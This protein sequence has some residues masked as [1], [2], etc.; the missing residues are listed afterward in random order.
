MDTKEIL[1]QLAK[2]I[3]DEREL[4]ANTATRVGSLF[5]AMV[6]FMGDGEFLHKDKEDVTKFLLECLGGL[7]VEKGLKADSLEVEGEST[8]GGKVTAN[9]L[10]TGNEGLIGKSAI[11]TE[12]NVCPGLTEIVEDSESDEVGTGF[13]EEVSEYTGNST[14]GGLLNVSSGADTAP[15]GTVLVMQNG[16]YVPEIHSI[17]LNLNATASE[18]WNLLI[19]NPNK[20]FFG[21]INSQTFDLTVSWPEQ[22][23]RVII[24]YTT[25]LKL[26]I[27]T[28]E[29]GSDSI[30]RIEEYIQ[31]ITLN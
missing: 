17:K 2:Q 19:A 22:G 31:Y 29:K 20:K 7:T 28:L 27:L 4:G 15:N 14:I 13:T 5:L 24:Q 30:E 26:N 23:K 3:R 18:L 12:N 10:V 16:T 25:Y 1:I 9:G 21:Y 11:P 6:E 8:L